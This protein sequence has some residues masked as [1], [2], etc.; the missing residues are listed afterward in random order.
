MAW[1]GTAKRFVCVR[2]FTRKTDAHF[3]FGTPGA[4]FRQ[5]AHFMFCFLGL[6]LGKGPRCGAPRR[7]PNLGKVQLESYACKAC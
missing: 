6:G 4:K 3:L 5:K 1:R 2:T 7:S